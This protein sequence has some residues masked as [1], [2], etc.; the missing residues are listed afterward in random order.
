MPVYY[1]QDFKSQL[2]QLEPLAERIAT[3]PVNIAPERDADLQEVLNGRPVRYQIDVRDGKAGFSVDPRTFV[4]KMPLAQL[5][6][7]W[8]M[9]YGF[10]T[11]FKVASKHW[12]RSET[13][14]QEEPELQE[15]LELLS[16]T[17]RGFREGKRL[18]WNHLPRPTAPSDAN[19]LENINRFFLGALGFILL[20][21]IGHYV[22]EHPSPQFQSDDESVK[23]EKKADRWAID[24]VFDK[25]PQ[26]ESARIFRG[27]CCTLALSLINLSEIHHAPQQWRLTHPPLVERILE[28]VTTSIPEFAGDQATRADSPIYLAAVILHVQRINLGLDV[29]PE[30]VHGSV[31]DYLIDA[32]RSFKNR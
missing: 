28:L 3:C 19:R 20:H 23:C 30:Q 15:P 29:I 24:W 7:L 8:A 6:R 26:E 32:L 11:A 27:Q 22:L 18:G 13:T 12:P 31:L 17:C 25:C 4:I 9:T 10:L 1:S 14:V 2:G 16:W 21:E 5:E